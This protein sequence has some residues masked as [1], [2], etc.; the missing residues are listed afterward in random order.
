MPGTPVGTSPP[1]WYLAGLLGLFVPLT[2]LERSFTAG[3]GQSV[4]TP[5]LGIVFGI[6]VLYG[7]RWIPALV[8]TL[9]GVSAIASATSSSGK[10]IDW[11]AITAVV[12]VLVAGYAI[13]AELARR[14]GV[15]ASLRR[16][17]DAAWLAVSA[18]LGTAVAIAVVIEVVKA[19]GYLHGQSLWPMFAEGC[20]SAGASTLAISPLVLLGG[21]GLTA[22]RQRRGRSN[23]LRPRIS[24]L[25]R[26]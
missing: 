10:P 2:L 11:P 9:L 16:L 21:D 12:A 24:T 18:M 14:V 6:M 20:A 7:T 8:A 13:G 1:W 5:A 4:W 25:R 3:A 26:I 15:R 23:S 22:A 17:S 19:L